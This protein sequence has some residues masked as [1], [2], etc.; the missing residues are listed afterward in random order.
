M[1]NY[2]VFQGDDTKQICGVTGASAAPDQFYFEPADYEG[3]TLWSVNFDT[4]EQAEAAAKK[5]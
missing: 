1:E 2:R 4:Y 3:D 5:A